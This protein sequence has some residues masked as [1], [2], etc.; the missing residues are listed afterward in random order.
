M[1]NKKHITKEL[2]S[3]FISICVAFTIVLICKHYLFS[4]V[5][6]D[7]ESMEPTYQDEDVLI[8]SKISDIQRFDQI[9][10]KSPVNDNYYIKRVIGLPGDT[11]EMKDD[12]LYINGEKYNEPYVNRK[13]EALQYTEDFT[14]EQL[15]GKE[16]V[17]E[18]YVFVLG[19][20]RLHSGDSRHYGFIAMD[21]ILGVSKVRIFP[22][23]Q[24]EIF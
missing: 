19:D 24:F 17:P 14:L 12:V 23:Q 8:I 20:N 1:D 10:F 16:T 15:T 4:P 5:V 6:V 9:V 7:G 2:L 13:E 22:I 11:I 21:E 18:G 3:W